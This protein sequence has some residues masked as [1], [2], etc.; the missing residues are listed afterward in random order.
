M[1]EV[2]KRKV[3]VDC[4]PGHDDMCAILLAAKHMELLGITT[5]HGNQSLEKTTKN[6]LKIVELAGLTHVPVAKG[7]PQSLLGWTNYA[8]RSMGNLDSTESICR[9]R[10]RPSTSCTRISSSRPSWKMTMSR[11]SPPVP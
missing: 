10:P 11:S 1:A 8:L 4:D 6:A 2:R 7:M 3:I 9:S 5:V